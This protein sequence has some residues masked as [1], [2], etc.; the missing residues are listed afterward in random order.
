MKSAL[1]LFILIIIKTNSFAQQKS[2]FIPENSSD[3]KLFVPKGWKM[4]LQTT[5]DLN[6]DGLADVVMVIE[7]TDPK[8]F[9]AGD[10]LGQRK[11]NINPRILLVIFK[12]NA[13][14]YRLAA[15]NSGFIPS[16]NDEVSSCLADPLMEEGGISI[17]NGSLK[18]SYQ[19]WSSCGS[20]YM[21]NKDYT[22][23][24]QSQKF[25]LIG[26]DDFNLHRSSGEQ[27]GTSINFSTRKMSETTGGN[28]FNEE[29]NKPKT[30][31]RTLRPSKLL[32]LATL[33]EDI[34]TDYLTRVAP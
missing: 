9:I 6:K 21:T 29:K 8:N 22:F 1:L 14:S 19:Y 2:P 28:E 30:V 34:F 27:S 16:Q 17:Q 33:T 3:L 26:Y 31:W 13:N 24:F 7:N 18:I 23:R 20:W 25:E 11:L 4:I 32:S 5:G 15:K 10:G 12:L